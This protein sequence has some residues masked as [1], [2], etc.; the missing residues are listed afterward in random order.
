MMIKA[1]EIKQEEENGKKKPKENRPQK[2][3]NGER[4]IFE[5]R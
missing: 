2:G 3:K 1:N 5:K 4:K